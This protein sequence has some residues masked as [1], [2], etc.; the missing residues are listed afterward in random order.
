MPT[1]N[2]YDFKS[3]QLKTTQALK[4]N[5]EEDRGPVFYS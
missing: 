5:P 3:N 2:Y 4:N 1:Q